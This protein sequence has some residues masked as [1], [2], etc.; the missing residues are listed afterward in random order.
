VTP[1]QLSPDDSKGIHGTDE[2]IPVGEIDRGVE[3]MRK[4]LALYAAPA[5]SA[6]A[7]ASR[8]R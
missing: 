8:G 7:V 6:A 1:F 4:V 2:R 5:A 3:R